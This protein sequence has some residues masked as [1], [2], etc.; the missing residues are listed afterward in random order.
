MSIFYGFVYQYL[1]IV[2]QNP[3]LETSKGIAFMSLTY[4]LYPLP[5]FILQFPGRDYSTILSYINETDPKIYQFFLAASC[6][7]RLSEKIITYI[8]I[9]VALFQNALVCI[10]GVIL[11]YRIFKRLT[12]IKHQ[13][14]F[15]TL[16]IS[17]QFFAVLIIQMTIPL[18]FIILPIGFIAVMVVLKVEEINGN[19]FSY[20]NLSFFEG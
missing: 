17:Q 20:L 11:A 3:F 7:G 15:A 2:K 16:K 9:S 4:L 5:T 10:I 19:Y 13:M 6:N 14:S 18:I 1:T 12:T 8:Y